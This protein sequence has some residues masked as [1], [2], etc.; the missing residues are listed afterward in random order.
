[1]DKQPDDSQNLLVITVGI[2]DAKNQLSGLLCKVQAGEEVVITRHGQPVAR[3]TGWTDGPGP[4]G[5]H[6]VFAAL[7]RLRA[8]TSGGREGSLSSLTHEGHF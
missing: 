3:L 8:G 7:A 2:F 6:R 5:C 4:A 1:M